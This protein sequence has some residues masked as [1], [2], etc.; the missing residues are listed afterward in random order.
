MTR[1][2]LLPLSLIALLAALSLGLVTLAQTTVAAPDNGVVSA[3]SAYG[4]DETIRRIKADIAAKGITFFLEIDQQKLAADAGIALPGR[5]TLL[6]FG[7]PALG[8]Q[9]ITSRREAGIDW[10][11]RLLITEDDATGKVL[12]IYNDFDWIARRHGIADRAEQFAMA[13]GVIT[14]ILGSV[15]R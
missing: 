6:I 14:S 1:R 2:T 7:N 12:A 8:T 11:V 3:P 5:S 15:A 10:P 13:T 4:F 9:F